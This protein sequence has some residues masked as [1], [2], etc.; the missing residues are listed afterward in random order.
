MMWKHVRY[1]RGPVGLL[2]A[3]VIGVGLTACIPPAYPP[4]IPIGASIAAG[5]GHACVVVGG[6]AVKCWGYNSNGQLGNGTTTDSNTPVDVTGVVGA[7]AIA[8]DAGAVH[9]CAIVGGGAVKCWGYNLYGQLG[10]GTNTDSTTAVDVTGVAGATAIAAGF[11]HTCAIV[12]GGAV[13]CWGDAGFGQLGNGTN[14]DSTTAVDVTGVAGATGI[15]GGFGHT[16]ALVAGGAVKC[17]AATT[18]DSWAS[19]RSTSAR[20]RRLTCPVLSVRPPSPPGISIRVRWWPVGRSSAGAQ[21]LSVSW[22][23]GPTP[24]RPRRWT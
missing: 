2:L 17:W 15:T 16:C 6:G 22:A 21:T 14:T 11:G 7:T 13:K 1:M 9:T 24:A 12:G 19:E 5:A 8:S 18:S 3:A 20:T 4:P 23:T 10:N